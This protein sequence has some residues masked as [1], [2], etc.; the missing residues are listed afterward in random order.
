LFALNTAYDS[1]VRIP[2]KT[3]GSAG[4]GVT[5]TTGLNGPDGLAVDAN[6]NH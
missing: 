6:D 4:A 2:V 3:D 1:I 5:F